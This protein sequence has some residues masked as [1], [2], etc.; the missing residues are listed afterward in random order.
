MACKIL[1][2]VFKQG[3]KLQE[4]GYEKV[5]REHL[6]SILEDVLCVLDRCSEITP[7]HFHSEG[8]NHHHDDDDDDEHTHESITVFDNTHESIT[9]FDKC[10]SVPQ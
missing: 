6:V 10:S 3:K 7:E 8:D 5:Y 1:F 9:V 4:D 2:L